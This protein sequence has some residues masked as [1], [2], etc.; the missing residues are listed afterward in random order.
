[1]ITSQAQQKKKKEQEED[2]FTVCTLVH[3]DTHI[4]TH[5][6]ICTAEKKKRRRRLLH[7]LHTHLHRYTNNFIYIKYN[8]PLSS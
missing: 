7:S 1:M 4:K 6:F 8:L 5:N 2:Y 3:I